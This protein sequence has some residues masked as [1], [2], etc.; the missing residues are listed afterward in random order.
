MLWG[1]QT[2]KPIN[3]AKNYATFCVPNSL[4][5]KKGAEWLDKHPEK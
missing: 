4:N 3:E 5:T 1:Q 2:I